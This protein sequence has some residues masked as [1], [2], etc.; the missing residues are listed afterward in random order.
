MERRS[1]VNETGRIQL[2]E[3]K[4]MDTRKHTRKE[5]TRPNNS[6]GHQHITLIL[7][8]NTH[9]ELGCKASWEK[10]L[11]LETEI[12]W[13]EIGKNIALGI[14]TKNDTSSWFKNIL[15]RAMY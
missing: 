14:E 2:P 7:A 10:R 6:Q 1:N 4:R 15:H 11:K 9:K 8:L 5:T 13:R 3:P 12:P